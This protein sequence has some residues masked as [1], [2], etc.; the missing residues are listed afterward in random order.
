MNTICSVEETHVAS[1]RTARRQVSSLPPVVSQGEGAGSWDR[2]VRPNWSSIEERSGSNTSGLGR[3][4]A[5]SIARR[6]IRERIASPGRPVFDNVR[7]PLR[8]RWA[9]RAERF[10]TS[11]GGFS[12]AL[13][14]IVLTLGLS[15]LVLGD[16]A[17]TV[18]PATSHQVAS[19]VSVD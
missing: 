10:V 9:D 13:G 2:P 5:P 12:I 19:Q 17:E 15:P 8:D 11:R 6:R 3:A 14:S 4:I 18:P 16:N 1:S 7:S